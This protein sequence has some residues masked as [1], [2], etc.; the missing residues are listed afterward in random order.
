MNNLKIFERQ[1]K[2][3]AEQKQSLAKVARKL[4][5]RNRNIENEYIV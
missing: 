3:F 2:P 1:K 5:H 4:I